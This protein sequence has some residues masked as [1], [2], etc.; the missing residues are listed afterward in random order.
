MLHSTDSGTASTVLKGTDSVACSIDPTL[1][2]DH[3]IDLPAVPPPVFDDEIHTKRFMEKDPAVMAASKVYLRMY[4]KGLSTVIFAIFAIFS[5]YWGSLW[6]I[7]AHSMRGWIIDFDGGDVGLTVVRNLT[8]APPHIIKWEV[9]PPRFF[10]LGEPEVIEAIKDN[11]A[12]VIIT[13][14]TAASSNLQ[15]AMV[16]P[17]PSYNGSRAITVY[18]VEARNEN[19]YRTLIRPNVQ[20]FLDAIKLDYATRLVSQLSSGTDTD[21][22]SLMSISPQTLVNPISYTLLNVIPFN[23]PVASAVVFVGLIYLLILSFF[24]V[25]IGF[26]ARQVSGLN[27]MLRLKSIIVL[28]LIS[29]FFAYFFLSF[30]YSLLNLAFKLDLTRRFGHSGF[31]LFWMLS[32]IGML[33]V[34]LALDALITL[35][36]PDYVPYFMILWIITNVAVCIFPIEILPFVYRY[37][38]VAPFYNISNSIRSIAFGTKNTLGRNFGVLFCWV[39]VSCVTL[40]LIQWYVRKKEARAA[41]RRVA[42]SSGLPQDPEKHVVL[43]SRIN[44]PPIQRYVRRKE[45][46]AAGLALQQHG[47]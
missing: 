12:W 2:F 26:K 40:P 18:G 13:I 36:G 38:H 17:D 9:I 29:S 30:F 39:L 41:A 21:V 31:F 6:R 10:P 42:V 20:M 43:L 27:R 23:Q 3:T 16:F 34:G 35:V 22:L 14:N 28:R 46:E 37:G 25:M 19:A 7:P 8:L 44:L 15:D 1:N 4:I 33:A 45:A 5:I 32:W 11:R 24:I 47:S